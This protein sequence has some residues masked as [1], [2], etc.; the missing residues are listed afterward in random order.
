MEPTANQTTDTSFPSPT[1]NG[2]TQSFATPPAPETAQ[3]APPP[4]PSDSVSTTTSTPSETQTI[5]T[6]GS[7]SGGGGRRRRIIMIGI[8]LVL[9]VTGI[10]SGTYLLSRQQVGTPFAW[11]CATYIFDVDETGAVTVRNGSTRDLPAQVADVYI[12]GQLVAEFEAPALDSGDSASLGVVE[13]PE[14]GRFS[15][16]VEGNKDC[17]NSDSYAPESVAQCLSVKAFDEEWEALDVEDLAALEE[18]DVVR[19]TIGG[20]TNQG[21]F[22]MARFTIN[23]EVTD[24]VTDKRPG[25]DE[26]YIEYEMPEDIT[27]FTIDAELMHSEA[28]WI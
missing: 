24:P 3:T 1:T 26:F 15:W 28:G 18:G 21:A 16:R 9:M 11:D 13:V 14:D 10:A 20:I 4:P 5:T 27:D 23:G 19:F 7:D 2:N 6:S 17:E 22:E 25:T 12:D 8:A